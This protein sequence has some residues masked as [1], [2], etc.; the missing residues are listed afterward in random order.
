MLRDGWKFEDAAAEAQKI[1]LREAPHLVEFAKKYI[2]KHQKS[3]ASSDLPAGPMQFGVFTARFDPGGT[4]SVEGDRWPKLNG[5][6]KKTGEELEL[7]TSSGPGG[8][9]RAGK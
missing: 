9:D 5:N 6:W 2:E 1:G 7:V 4:F 8:C 3:A